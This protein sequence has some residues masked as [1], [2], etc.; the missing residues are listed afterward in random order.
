MKKLLSVILCLS[1][2]TTLL[3]GASSVS[4]D[5]IIVE[6]DG[7]PI[8]FDVKPEIIDGRTMVPL[9]KI[10]E[11][12]GALVKWDNDTQTVSARK[13]KKTITL[14]IDSAD[15]QI[16]KGDT[17]EEGN[18]I[19]DRDSTPNNLTEDSIKNINKFLN[20]ARHNSKLDIRNYLKEQ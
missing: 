12:I 16:D 20:L 9:R 15:L 1:L 4:A 11:E 18:P 8:E 5:E 14:S 13:N 2:V 6:L 19:D 10:F 7:N 17:D 3:M